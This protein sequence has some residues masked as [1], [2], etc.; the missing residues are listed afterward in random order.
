MIIRGE[1]RDTKTIMV[2]QY[3]TDR[4]NFLTQSGPSSMVLPQ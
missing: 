4:T 3:F 1:I 2:S